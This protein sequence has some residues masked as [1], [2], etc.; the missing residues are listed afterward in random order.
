MPPL[1]LRRLCAARLWMLPAVALQLAIVALPAQN[2]AG[3]SI[4]AVPLSDLGT[5]TYLGFQGGLYPGGQNTPPPAHAALGQAAMANVTPRDALGMPAAGGRIGLVSLGMSNTTQEFSTWVAMAN[6]DPNRNGQVTVVDGAQGGQDA[7]VLANPAANFWTVV[8]QRLAVAGLTPEQVQVVWLKEAIAGVS[9]GFPGGAQQLQSLLGQIAR[10]VKTRYPNVELCFC[11]S[12]TYA[13]YA[14]V[15]L[16]P[17]PYAYESGFAVQ[18]LIGQQI[19]GDPQLNSDPAAEPAVAP[20]LGF[21]PYLWTDGTTPRSDGLVWNCADTEADGTH[22]SALGEAKV[23]GLLQQF[24]TTNALATPW[25][26]GAGGTAATFVVYGTGCAGS[27]GVPGMRSNGLPR[28]G[29]SSFRIGVD[30]AA[31]NAV[32]ALLV[33]GAPGNV[34]VAGPCA[35]Q[36]DPAFGLPALF[37]VTNGA[38]ARQEPLAIPNAA[39]FV[40]L[41]LF[42]QWAIFDALGT[43]VP[44]L[45]GLAGSRGGQLTVGW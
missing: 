19:A 23:A 34:P 35:L 29:N 42:A 8:D 39:G 20:W 45:P 2:C 41:Q 16:N 37:G 43:Q 28:V 24:F 15:Q 7:V 14:T 27:N 12:R 30:H 44:G 26:V 33:S 17:E 9:G 3:T 32:A 6:A 21:G 40:G 31:Q 11:S 13:G 18:W 10:N 4:G 38:G 5:G 22:P 25:Y 36:L 1:S